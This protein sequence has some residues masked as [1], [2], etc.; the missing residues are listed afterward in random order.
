MKE[1]TR[2]EKLEVF[3]KMLLQDMELIEQMTEGLKRK[4]PFLD[5]NVSFDKDLDKANDY[6]DG[7]MPEYEVIDDDSDE[8]DDND[9]LYFL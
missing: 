8:V 4:Y 7:F 6:F 2:N 1:I 9:E 3:E 5:V